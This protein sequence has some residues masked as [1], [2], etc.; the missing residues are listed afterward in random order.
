MSFRLDSGEWR[1]SGEFAHIRAVSPGGARYDPSYA[2]VNSSQN[3]LLMCPV[4]HYLVDSNPDS[5]PIELLEEWLHL[6]VSSPSR[7]TPEL[8]RER[9]IWSYA[10]ARSRLATTKPEQ[11]DRGWGMLPQH[12]WDLRRKLWIPREEAPLLEVSRPRLASIFDRTKTRGVRL[13]PER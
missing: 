3:L 5:H 13:Y 1:S 2:E 6:E 11:R 8:P 10:S 7:P 4:H 9:E 12:R